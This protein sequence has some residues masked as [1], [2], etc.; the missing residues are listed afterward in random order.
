[1]SAAAITANV[2]TNTD[3]LHHSQ[4]SA[5]LNGVPVPSNNHITPL[6]DQSTSTT[7]DNANGN[8]P[9]TPTLIPANTPVFPMDTQSLATGIQSNSFAVKKGVPII[10]KMAPFIEANKPFY[11]FEYF[12]PKT[13][14]GVEN[15]Y[16]RLD[17]MSQF[18]PLFMDLTWGAG[19]STAELTLEI[20]GNGQQMCSGE[21]MMHLTCT[22]LPTSEVK[23]ALE[24]A[25]QLGIRNILALRGDPPK[26]S[27]AWEACENGFQQA[28]DL[29]K[30]IRAEYGDFFGVAVAGYPEGH[31]SA[32]S[33]EE[34]VRFLKEKCDAGADFIIT[35]LF[36]DTDVF[37]K[38]VDQCRAAGITCPIIPGIMPIQNYTGFKRMTSFCN[39]ASH[40]L[41]PRNR[42][43][44]AATA[45]A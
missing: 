20:S 41:H 44:M 10:R 29:V 33:M 21:I 31:I 12:P 3:P 40:I 19:G 8:Q 9:H 45:L 4:N 18:E 16:E 23:I 22:N 30:F 2:S 26:G 43:S 11:S 24:K 32:A 27:E 15:L 38:W 1:M 13:R 39:C 25:K 5:P 42:Q 28:V 35:Q 34:D 37:L 17:R 7:S 14:E 36:Y 6:S